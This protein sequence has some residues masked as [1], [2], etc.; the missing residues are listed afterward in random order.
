MTNEE[1][2]K[3]CEEM[4]REYMHTF[5]SEILDGAEYFDKCIE[6]L[7][8]SIPEQVYLEGDGERD[9]RIVYDMAKCSCGKMF[10]DGDDDWECNYCPQCSQKLKWFEEEQKNVKC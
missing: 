7:K 9:G 4:R 6:A 8:K 2:L 3:K 5:N 10:E 1:A